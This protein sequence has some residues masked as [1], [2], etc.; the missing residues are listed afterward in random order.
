MMHTYDPTMGEIYAPSHDKEWR[1]EV[2]RRAEEEIRE[3]D[4]E[5]FYDMLGFDGIHRYSMGNSDMIYEVAKQLR[6]FLADD[7]FVGVGRLVSAI[8]WDAYM[9]DAE[10]EMDDEQWE[11]TNVAED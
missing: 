8:I 3:G 5:R 6:K 1:D 4:Y 2:Y 9:I 10:R 7:D 11:P